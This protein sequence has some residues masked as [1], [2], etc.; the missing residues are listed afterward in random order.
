MDRLPWASWHWLVVIGLG[1][2]VDPRRARGHDRRH[3]REPPDRG[4]LGHRAHG[5]PDRPGRGDLRRRRVPRRAVL[6]PPRRPDGPQEA[7]HDHAARLPGRHRGDRVLGLVPVVRGL[8]LLH[9]R[10]HRR[11]VRGDQL[12]DR[13]ADPRAR[14]RHRRPDHQR[15]VLAR[16]R[17]R[18]RCSR[19]CCSTSRC[20]P[21]TSAGAS[22]SGSA[23]SSA[24]G[25]CS[26]AATCRSRRAGCS[27]TAATR[28]PRRSSPTSSATV[29]GGDRAGARGAAPHDQGPPAPRDRL[30]HR[31][32]RRSSSSTRSGRCSG[33]SLFIGQAFL[34]NSVFF[35]YALVLDK[36]YGVGA[37]QVGWYIAAFAVGNFVGPLRARAA[38][39]TR[40]GAS[41]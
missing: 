11:R 8:P 13:R 39:S 34:Y 40:S 20:S 36:F 4:R 25:S 30:R 24:S 37:D 41:R 32:P 22:R 21:P 23:R 29:R 1:R 19:S 3:D 12:G 6:R 38:S 7:V 18:A 5:V 26:C 27:S 33:S 17:R 2:G 28:R 15:L 16:H 35:T 14:A 10:G 9:R 31:R